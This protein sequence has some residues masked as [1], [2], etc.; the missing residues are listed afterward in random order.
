[1]TRVDGCGAMPCD[2][3]QSLRQAAQRGRIS[4]TL[5][6]ICAAVFRRFLGIVGALNLE[7]RSYKSDLFDQMATKHYCARV[8]GAAGRRRFWEVASGANAV[9]LRK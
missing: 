9:A 7:I 3:V 4:L 6:R 2:A 8:S 1:M 5:R